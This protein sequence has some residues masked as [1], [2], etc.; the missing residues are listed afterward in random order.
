MNETATPQEIIASEHLRLLAI[1]YVF[2]AI[3]SALMSLLGLLYAGIGFVMS[4]FFAQATMNAT[5]PEKIPPE[6]LG[7]IVSVFGGAFFVVLMA[8]ALLKFYAASC[9]RR[10]KSRLFCQIVAGISC[11]AIPY[12]TLLGVFTFVVLGRANV[13]RWFDARTNDAA[14]S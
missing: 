6:A 12:G 5:H 14:A 9:I 10:R 8:L 11:L 13:V 3:M 2:S 7:I 1:G 4:H